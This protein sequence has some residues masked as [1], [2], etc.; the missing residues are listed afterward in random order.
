MLHLR[1]LA[2]AA[3]S[4]GSIP[5]NLIR[6]SLILSR[7]PIVTPEVSEFD[8][9][10]YNYQEE[11]EKR[12][13]WT[14]PKW[15]YFKKGT[16]AEKEFT[17]IQKYPIPAH[18]GVWFPK[19]VPELK[20]GRDRRFKQEVTLANKVSEGDSQD[21]ENVSRPI[22]P[23]SRI[24]EADKTNDETSLERKLPR[25]LYLLVKQDGKWKF[26]TFQVKDDQVALNEVAES[27]LR[28]LGGDKIN[29]W[30]VSGTPAAVIK[31]SNGE[32][33]DEGHEGVV[34]EYLMKSHIVA[35]QFVPEGLEYKWLAKEEVEGVVDPKYYEK[36][37]YLLSN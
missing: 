22:T 12:L 13:M 37:G 24:T 17:K 30:S 1:G 25:T 3:S 28:E 31:Y 15:F 34:R 21:L 20:H 23:N 7:I 6:T 11:L 16:V 33:V 10:F 4:N 36:V 27:G 32:I 9:K 8:A 18:R 29:T 5:I 19:G 35:G 2:T 26:P 14:F